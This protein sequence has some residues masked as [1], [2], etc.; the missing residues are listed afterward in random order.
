MLA[1]PRPDDLTS[2]ILRTDFTNDIAWTELQAMVGLDGATY[3]SD[4]RYSGATIDAL[5]EADAAAPD[6][7]KLTHV[8]VLMHR[9]CFSLSTLCWW[10]ISMTSPGAHS[11]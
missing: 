7:D 6:D 2:L 3:V 9:R 11:A 1:P 5:V 8:F 4:V 10:W